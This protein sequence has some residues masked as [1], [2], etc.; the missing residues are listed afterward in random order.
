M[1]HLPDGRASHTDAAV[2]STRLVV[3]EETSQAFT[4]WRRRR[5]GSGA[6]CHRLRNHLR[7]TDQRRLL[8]GGVPRAK[9]PVTHSADS[10]QRGV[11][12]EVSPV[13][14]KV[15][16]RQVLPLESVVPQPANVDL[17]SWPRNCSI[18]RSLRQPKD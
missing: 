10:R 4:N 2:T 1:R 16:S 13:G 14:E 8:N 15:R 9:L 6:C 11:S 17:P 7:S 12:A 5:V 3:E 18:E